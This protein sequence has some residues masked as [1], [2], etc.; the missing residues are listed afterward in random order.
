MQYPFPSLTTQLTVSDV[1]LLLGRKRQLTCSLPK[2]WFRRWHPHHSC[3][4]CSL[5]RAYQKS[6]L[7][8]LSSFRKPADDPFLTAFHSKELEGRRGL[9]KSESKNSSV[10]SGEQRK[11]AHSLFFVFPSGTQKL[12]PNPSSTTAISIFPFLPTSLVSMLS[13]HMI[14]SSVKKAP[15]CESSLLYFKYKSTKLKS[16]V[17][18]RLIV[19]YILIAR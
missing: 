13:P 1:T 12:C 2:N 19:Q 16:S 11:S 10:K 6:L 17:H 15:F 4:A 14:N 7:L 3:T 5:L 18:C 9:K 8:Q